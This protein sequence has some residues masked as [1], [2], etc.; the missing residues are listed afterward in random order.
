MHAHG[1]CPHAPSLALAGVP[2]W[3]SLWSPGARQRVLVRV[4]AP[5]GVEV[6]LR[7]PLPAPPPFK[8]R[9]LRASS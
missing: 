8:V 7:P 5:K 4:W 3:I 6:F 2:G 1:C 9:A